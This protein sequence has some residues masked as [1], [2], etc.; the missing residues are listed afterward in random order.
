MN[1]SLSVSELKEY[2]SKQLDNF[3]PDQYR[4]DGVDVDKALDMALQR[5]EYCF[6]HVSQPHYFKEGNVCFSHRHSDQ[7]TAFLYF[8]SNSLWL[9]SQNKPLCDKLFLLN[10]AL[11]AVFVSYKCELP[12]IFI[13]DHA[14][15]TVIGNAKYSDFLVI[16]QNVT[17]NTGDD[18]GVWIPPELG[19]G[20]FLGAGAKIIGN[21]KIG[22]FVSI[23]VNSCVFKID[24]P[25]NSIVFTDSSGKLNIKENKN[26]C[27]AQNFFN[28]DIRKESKR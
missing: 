22:D 23:G 28:V 19:R 26:Q 16:F 18:N 15:G 12:D 11:N 25:D 5:M 17:V 8:L 6:K 3:F 10:R 7:Y 24:V 27:Y 2:V 14:V 13:F 21:N 4:F 9:E 20:V 1:L